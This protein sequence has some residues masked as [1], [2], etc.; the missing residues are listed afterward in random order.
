[1]PRDRG[2]QAL[3]FSGQTGMPVLLRQKSRQDAGVT[4][5]R[6]NN[7]AIVSFRCDA[8]HLATCGTGRNACATESQRRRPEASGTKSEKTKAMVRRDGLLF[9]GRL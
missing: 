9:S 7:A 6:Q 2:A 3:R 8:K 1:M 5:E 4:G